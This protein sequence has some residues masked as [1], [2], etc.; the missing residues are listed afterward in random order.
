LVVRDDGRG[1]PPGHVEG[2]GITGM[3]ER[4]L[5]VGGRLTVAAVPGGGTETRLDVPLPGGLA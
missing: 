4:A 5:H 3:R 2:D 1:L